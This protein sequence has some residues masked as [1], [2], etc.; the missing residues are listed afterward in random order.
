M[1][2]LHFLNHIKSK[3]RMAGDGEKKP[4]DGAVGDK[5]DGASKSVRD[6]A[7][8]SVSQ[9]K[10]LVGGNVNQ[11]KDF[12]GANVEQAKELTST[13]RIAIRRVG[14]QA[15]NGLK[16]AVSPVVQIF[17]KAESADG[18]EMRKHISTARVQL[19][20]Q[21]KDAQVRGQCAI[22]NP[23]LAIARSHDA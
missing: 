18:T 3:A 11:V 21:L 5:L 13:A 1:K 16:T 17:E 22:T 20:E 6:A 15:L 2:K 14:T 23:L 10:N 7:S 8:D 19:N 12:F 4:W 9:V